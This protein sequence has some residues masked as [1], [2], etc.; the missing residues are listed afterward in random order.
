MPQCP[1]SLQSKASRL[2]SSSRFFDTDVQKIKHYQLDIRPLSSSLTKHGPCNKCSDLA[3]EGDMKLALS[4]FRGSTTVPAL[5][6]QSLPASQH[7][8]AAPVHRWTLQC[9]TA[10]HV[11]VEWLWISSQLIHLT[12]ALHN[13][14]SST[15][16]LMTKLEAPRPMGCDLCTFTWVPAIGRWGT[17]P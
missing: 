2:P 8:A 14:A 5:H 10:P 3:L 17:L 16:N 1:N 12:K 9:S 6:P 7:S 11:H 4:L 15:A 13:R